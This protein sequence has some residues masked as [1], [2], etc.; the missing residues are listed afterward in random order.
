REVYVPGYY[1]SRRYLNN[2]NVSNTVIVNNTYITNIYNGRGRNFDY[3]FARDPHAV[4]VVARDR[5]IGGLPLD[6]HLAH[7]PANDLR[8]LH[9]D[10]R[11]PALAPNRDS[12]FASRVLGRI[13]GRV[14]NNDDDDTQGVDRQPTPRD[15]VVRNDLTTRGRISRVPFD[16]ERNAIVAN[17]GRPVGR[18]QLITTTPRANAQPNPQVSPQPNS[19]TAPSRSGDAW[20]IQRDPSRAEARNTTRGEVATESLSNDDAAN[21]RSFA[22]RPASAQ[23]P[24]RAQR[25]FG[26][27]NRGSENRMQIPEQR[28][29]SRGNDESARRARESMPSSAPSANALQEQPRSNVSEPAAGQT[30]R[31]WRNDDRPARVER[32]AEPRSYSEPRSYNPPAVERQQAPARSWQ[33]PSNQAQPQPYRAPQ[34]RVEQPRNDSPPPARQPRADSGSSDRTPRS[35]NNSNNGNGSGSRQDWRKV[36]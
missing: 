22:D 23:Q 29:W 2:I 34:P 1:Y 21:A 28:T 11:P 13:P 33:Q 30:S 8:R 14:R 27:E 17:G 24:D 35:N 5:F 36:Q 26:N 18:N 9:P 3:R 4:T 15:G 7:V 10:P 6:G 12:V 19:Q 31:Q 16:V 25:A 20:R 32:S